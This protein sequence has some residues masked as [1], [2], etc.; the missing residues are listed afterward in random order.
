MISTLIEIMLF[1]ST[2]ILESFSS[3]SLT[4][5]AQESTAKADRVQEIMK[6]VS[7]NMIGIVDK[8]PKDLVKAKQLSKDVADSIHDI[9]QAG[10]QLDTMSRIV[11]NITNLISD[12]GSKQTSID[13][14]GSILQKK[15]DDLKHS[16]ANAR[17]LADRFKIGL[18][19]YRNTTLELKNPE[20][21]PL[22]A[23]STKL[24]AYFRTNQTNGFLFY[25]GNEQK[26]KPTR[27]KTVSR[28]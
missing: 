15:I 4:P 27:S 5:L 8:L 24:S 3:Q 2:S 13:S 11:P 1:F 10:K 26:E 21:L 28:R 17:E 12:L 7:N 18:T 19:F 9:S 6:Q 14:T 25:L 22:L 16:I 23:T 20:S